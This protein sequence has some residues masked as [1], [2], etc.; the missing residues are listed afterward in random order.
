MT[1]FDYVEVPTPKKS[2][3]DLSYSNKLTMDFGDLVPVYKQEVLPGDEF[4]ASAQFMVRMA[5][6][7]NPIFT[8]VNAQI[9]YFFVPNR[10]LWDNKGWENFITGGKDGTLTPTPPYLQLSTVYSHADF[11]TSSASK[12]QTLALDKSPPFNHFSL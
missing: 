5:P 12:A 10:L 8:K 11:D 9:H 4:K 6:L 1:N 2:G 7:A 3:F